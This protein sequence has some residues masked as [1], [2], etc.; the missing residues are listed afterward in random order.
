[1]MS[2]RSHTVCIRCGGKGCDF[3]HKGWEC[4]GPSVKNVLFLDLL[5]MSVCK[6][7]KAYGPIK[8]DPW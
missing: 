7:V 4:E 6:S 5:K 2:D 8:N 1:M 3:C